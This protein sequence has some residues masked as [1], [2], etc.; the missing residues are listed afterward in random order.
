MAYNSLTSKR[1]TAAILILSN[2]QHVSDKKCFPIRG[3][4]LG[5][6]A[7]MTPGTLTSNVN[8]TSNSVSRT[9]LFLSDVM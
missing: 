1:Q 9:M 5:C 3:E 8:S 4:H 6:Y 7:V 2:R